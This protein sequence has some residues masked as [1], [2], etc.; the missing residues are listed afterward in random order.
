M[1][2]DTLARNGIRGIAEEMNIDIDDPIYAKN[3]TSKGKRL[4][5]FLQTVDKTTVVRTLNAL[6]EYR[7]VVRQRARN[8]DKVKNA[9]G[10]LLAIINRLN[11]GE[12]QPSQIKVP[13]TPAFD[14]DLYP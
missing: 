1:L 6:W 3:G 2:R 14:R 9:H 10:Q 7:E 13:P 5:C 4:R 12:M 11:S 8:E